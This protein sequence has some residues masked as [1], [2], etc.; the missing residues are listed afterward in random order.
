[1]SNRWTN[2]QLE[3]INNSG[4]NLL[5]SAAAGSGKTAVLVE[6]IC[7]KIINEG[8]SVDD[9]V[10]VTFTKAAAAEMKTRLRNKINDELAEAIK[11]NDTALK[12][13]LLQQKVLLLD[14]K[15]TTIDS[16]CLDIVKTYF[17]EAGVEPGFRTP[18]A[19]E[20]EL[21]KQDAYDELIDELS[22]EN[23][24]DL[25]D[26]IE[27]YGD[28]RK[29]NIKDI[30]DKIYTAGL[31]KPWPK[32]WLESL[33][34]SEDDNVDEVHL[35]SY[36]DDIKKKVSNGY[37]EAVNLLQRMPET[38]K[39]NDLKSF[40]YEELSVINSFLETE[41]VN[42]SLQFILNNIEFKRFPSLRNLEDYEAEAK[43]KYKDIRDSIKELLSDKFLM[44]LKDEACE[45]IRD[46]EINVTNSLLNMVKRYFE[47]ID[48]E[49]KRK[50]LVTFS[51]MEHLALEVLAKHG[52]SEPSEIAIALKEKY[53]EIMVDEYQDSNDIQ[54]TI[55]SVISK[56][57]SGNRYIVGDVKQSIYGFRSAKPDIFMGFY[58]SFDLSKCSIESNCDLSSEF[59]EYDEESI[60]ETVLLQNN[61]R[62]RQGVVDSTN[63]CFKALF[64][65][66]YNSMDYTARDELV[67][68]ASFPE[69]ENVPGE[70]FAGENGICE[71]YP[72]L[73]AKNGV[74]NIHK[75]ALFIANKIK[76]LMD[77]NTL[78]YDK[79]E[80]RYR[81]IKYRD[82]VL[83]ARNNT[84]ARQY[85]EI[86]M[87]E[88]ISVYAESSVSFL[89]TYEIKPVISLLSVIDNPHQDIPLMGAMTGY[90]GGFT[91]TEAAI[92]K[93]FSP[94][95]GLYESLLNYIGEYEGPHI[96][97]GVE[98]DV[99][100]QKDMEVDTG[101][102]KNTDSPDTAIQEKIR[103]FLKRVEKYRKMLLT[104]GVHDLIWNII[105]STGYFDFIS[106]LESP[107]IR[108]ANINFLLSNAL[109]FE[110]SN[111]NS[112]FQ[113]L[114]YIEKIIK[115]DIEIGSGS[116]IDEND[117]VVRFMTIHKSKGLEFPVVFLV[118]MTGMFNMTD[119]RS[120]VIVSDD[121]IGLDVVDKDTRVKYR[122]VIK[123]SIKKKVKK[124]LISEEM[125]LLYVAMTRAREKLYLVG[126]VDEDKMEKYKS[127]ALEGNEKLSYMRCDSLNSYFDMVM[128]A[129]L[130][131]NNSD[132]FKLKEVWDSNI[133]SNPDAHITIDNVDGDKTKKCERLARIP[134][135]YEDETH[136]RP[137]ISVS[138]LMS[139]NIN[140][141]DYEFDEYFNIYKDRS[142]DGNEATAVDED[143]VGK[144]LTSDI[145]NSNHV[146][147]Y[148]RKTQNTSASRG[149]AYHKVMECLDFNNAST[150]EDID[151][152]IVAMEAEG[153]LTKEAAQ[154][155]YKRDILT[156]VSS[157]FGKVIA[158]AQNKNVLHRE[159]EFMIGIPKEDGDDILIVQGAI[160]MYIEYE[161]HI[162]LIDFKTDNVRRNKNP[163]DILVDRYSEQI[164][165]YSKALEQVTEK[166]VTEKY[167]YSFCLG[168]VIAVNMD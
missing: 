47:K 52:T 131:R 10:V 130:N 49:K 22:F 39:L 94:E 122:T 75:E 161:D 96:Q 104:D 55:L 58:D 87:N 113:F 45:N 7:N 73:Y 139:G 103:T 146:S 36:I 111:Y 132:Y 26:L 31:S 9:I 105:Y 16:F 138:E 125:R 8:I 129:V 74:K 41:D 145:A 70:T 62:S 14:A 157:E 48:K 89:D 135:A 116:V 95:L 110:K 108:I 140:L 120:K 151:S 115:D 1:M 64:N 83:L 136:N 154:S 134:Y 67:C 28:V 51:D 166:K 117:D 15:I 152:Q 37:Q 69:N 91:Q 90:F 112:L 141:S 98:E 137:K 35:Q 159:Q 56:D 107:E 153:L 33:Y 79:D 81:P 162:V 133:L 19:A 13:R 163:E 82:I 156:L 167:I 149:T 2:A 168:K 150:L 84:R 34:R 86:L 20:M 29:V 27:V 143:V 88:G 77:S 102:Q 43:D 155:I 21:I 127:E 85:V 101:A 78:V 42:L 106:N 148:N 76:K 128:P 144:A 114:K 119:N 109:S 59:K 44:Q 50:K 53:N 68:S 18:D 12:E 164:Y 57:G 147:K 126:C 80:G 32:E 71:I 121:A 65:R 100:I 30:L 60:G 40:A 5:I 93:S 17:E 160:D 24:S 6:R 99:S 118:N 46:I 124:D 165:Y 38:E 23:D 66:E 123:E 92:I 54:E 3:A 63:A 4:H 158:D 142:D 97:E 25:F 61:F 11:N 72:I